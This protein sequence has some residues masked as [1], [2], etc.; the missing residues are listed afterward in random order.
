MTNIELAREF[1]A[2]I[3]EL[4]A[5]AEEAISTAEGATIHQITT[6]NDGKAVAFESAIDLLK[7]QA[8]SLLN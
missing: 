5:L 2:V 4:E 8:N 1:T 3:E 7:R 6:Y